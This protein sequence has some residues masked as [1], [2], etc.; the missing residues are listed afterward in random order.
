MSIK[1][2]IFVMLSHNT[3]KITVTALSPALSLTHHETQM[4]WEKAA[5]ALR[6]DGARPKEVHPFFHWY[7]FLS[8]IFQDRTRDADGDVIGKIPFRL[9]YCPNLRWELPSSSRAIMD[10]YQPAS[11]GVQWPECI[12]TPET[13]VNTKTPCIP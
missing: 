2:F 5:Q 4:E 3:P 7:T 11:Y 12:D 8:F 9:H 13:R 10:K 1:R 6:R